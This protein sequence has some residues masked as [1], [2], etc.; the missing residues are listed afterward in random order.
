LINKLPD[1]PRDY[2]K[3]NNLP[4]ETSCI[5]TELISNKRVSQKQTVNKH[6]VNLLHTKC[7]NSCYKKIWNLAVQMCAV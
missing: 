6:E 2:A 5:Q 3:P 4:S 1:D 7:Q